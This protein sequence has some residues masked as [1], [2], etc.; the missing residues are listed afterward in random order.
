M[1]RFIKL[2]LLFVAAAVPLQANAL[3]DQSQ[4]RV[5]HAET[6]PF[7][8]LQP[9]EVIYYVSPQGTI[10]PTFYYLYRT[11]NQTYINLL[12]AALISGKQVRVTGN[13]GVCPGAGAIRAA[14]QVVAV[15]MD[16][17]N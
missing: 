11:S 17:F 8:V 6:S 4:A 3:C 15:F 16:S 5:I 2:I 10:T 14:G 12:N 7:N 9:A 1:K 13:A